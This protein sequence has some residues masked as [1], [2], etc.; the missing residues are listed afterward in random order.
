M[1]TIIPNWHPIL[2]HFTIALLST[3]VLFYL[4][5]AL[6]PNNHHWKEQWLSMA[7]WSLWSGCLFAIATV[8]AG[9]FAYNTVTHDE[10]SHAAMTLHRN[11]AVPT[12][13][14]FLII[15][16]SA[17][18]IARKNCVPGVRFLSVSI[19]ASV[20]LMVTGW[21]GAETVYRYGLGVMSLPQVEVGADGH[22]HSHGEEPEVT[23]A[24]QLDHVD[25]VEQQPHAHTPDSKVTT[26]S[27]DTT[28][29][30]PA[31]PD[32]HDDSPDS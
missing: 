29:K 13:I 25:T 9:W 10:A 8:I 6:L 24:R 18:N 4:A 16:V 3:S 1:I 14:L 5:R 26:D 32:H 7:N 21:L 17:I 15:G 11:W 27:L 12:A 30:M 19:I 2:V 23:S 20:M 31:E 22:N 28:V